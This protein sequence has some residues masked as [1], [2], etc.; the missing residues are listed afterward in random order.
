MAVLPRLGIRLFL[1]ALFCLP[2]AARAQSGGASVRVSGAVGETVTLSI[3]HGAESYAEG[4]RV[5]SN[6]TPDRRLIITLSGA[7]R[8]PTRV[9]VPVQI[10]SNAGYRLLAAAKAGGSD[11]SGFAVVDA[12]P[13]GS[14][15]A[16]EAVEALSVA[17]MFDARPCAGRPIPDGGSKRPGLSSPFELLSGPR[18]SLGGVPGSPQN[19]LEVVLSVV[20]EPRPDERVWTVELLLSAE[21]GGARLSGPRP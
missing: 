16:A 11:L 18:V 19:A 6:Q 20:V 3:P 17:A 1:T 12:R 7:T 4:V 13:T 5:A 15:V 9:G 8:G 10:R 2:G 21:P 14:L